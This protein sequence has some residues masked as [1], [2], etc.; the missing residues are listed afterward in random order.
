MQKK[1][2]RKSIDSV[3]WLEQKYP[4]SLPFWV[5]DSDYPTAK[6]IIKD[7]EKVLK[8]GA[9]GYPGNDEYLKEI[10]TSWYLTTYH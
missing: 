8:V 9:F 3:K 2:N 4:D 5:A 1:I 6:C 7:L 10:I